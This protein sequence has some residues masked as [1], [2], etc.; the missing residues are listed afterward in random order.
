MQLPI[1]SDEVR[2]MG[3]IP[4]F[5]IV[6]AITYFLNHL[7]WAGLSFNNFRDFPNA[8][9][10]KTNYMKRA[11]LTFRAEALSDMQVHKRTI[12]GITLVMTNK[13]SRLISLVSKVA[14]CS[15]LDNANIVCKERVIALL[16]VLPD[17]LG[18]KTNEVK[19]FM[20]THSQ[21]QKHNISTFPINSNF[22]LNFKF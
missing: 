21:I 12:T 7:I 1:K 9:V 5:Q 18:F 11:K 20:K 19:T 6:Q 17:F 16:Q 2:D 8:Q 14:K 22:L 10:C 13:V 3:D 15:T 4:S